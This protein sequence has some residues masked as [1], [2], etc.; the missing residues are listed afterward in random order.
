M[1]NSSRGIAVNGQR[2]REKRVSKKL[3]QADL[4]KRANVSRTSIACMENRSEF[5]FDAL[6]VGTV[7]EALGVK[8]EYLIEEK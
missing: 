6:T 4:A 2:V 3:T 1:K 5:R 8:T 7:A